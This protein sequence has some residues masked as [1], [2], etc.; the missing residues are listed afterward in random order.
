MIK[1]DLSDFSKYRNELMGISAIL[2]WVCHAYGYVELPISLQYVLSLG[3][4][5]VDLFLFLSGMGLWYSL[6]KSYRGGVKCWYQSRFKKLL[7]PYLLITIPFDIIKV[8]SGKSVADNFLDYIFGLSTLRF[9]VSHDTPWFIAAIIPLYLLAPLF[10]R[11]I[12]KYKWR[13]FI[14]LITLHY[15][16]LLIPSSVGPV[17]LNNLIENSQFVIVRAT[18]FILGM[19]LGESVMVGKRISY[20][21]IIG[22]CIMGC[23]S[24]GLT[25]HLVYGYFWFC[26][27]VLVVFCYFINVLGKYIMSFIGFMGNISLESY[28]LN[29]IIP[30]FIVSVF[31]NFELPLVN[32]VVSYIV[33]CLISIPIGYGFSRLS[34]RI[35]SCINIP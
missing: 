18:A 35:L 11:L 20:W 14:A 1:T 6:E 32:G 26:I 10:Y 2:I 8:C 31:L 17:V 13:A 30:S 3:N 9:Y 7:V 4:I 24:I 29:G 5:G 28:L 12:K 16:L 23:V 34:N 21:W 27:P 25:R 33:A 19:A 15:C 22:A